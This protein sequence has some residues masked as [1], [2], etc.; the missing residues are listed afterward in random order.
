ML[1][2]LRQLYR[3]KM[4]LIGVSLVAAGILG[5]VV[6]SYTNASW[7]RDLGSAALQGGLLSVIVQIVVDGVSERRQAELMR[8]A[9][10]QEAPAI[11]DAVLDSLAFRPEALKQVASP[12]TLDRLAVNALGLRLGNPALAADAYRDL[13]FQLGTTEERWHDVSISVSLRPWTPRN[14]TSSA[15]F[16]EAT[17]RWEYRVTPATP[18]LRFACVSDLDEYR[19]LL[20]DPTV[21]SVWFSEL[22]ASSRDTFDVQHLAVD[23]KT[24]PV[25]RSRRKQGQVFTAD[26]GTTAGREVVLSYTYRILVQQRGNV[27]Y[28]NL[29]QPSHNLRIHLDYDGTG[30]QHVT[31]LDYI[32]GAQPVRI[33]RTDSTATAARVDIGFDGWVLA[34]SGVAFV[35]VTGRKKP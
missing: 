27:L 18:V 34:Q 13:Q 24:R 8:S 17:I 19:T 26:L 20:N 21:A 6:G 5:L 11:R 16:F 3:A 14:A 23:G 35:W 4:L 22:D 33:E 28:L 30:I 31:T 2:L 10:R 7:V 32:A 12:E 29:N 15:D 25:R 9:V 1:D